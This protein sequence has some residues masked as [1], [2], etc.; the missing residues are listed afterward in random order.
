[1]VLAGASEP[2]WGP[3][4]VGGAAMGGRL[5]ALGRAGVNRLRVSTPGLRPGSHRLTITAAGKRASV[6][7][8]ILR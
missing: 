4:D 8:R 6:R 3:V 7:P 5:G 1:V 2:G